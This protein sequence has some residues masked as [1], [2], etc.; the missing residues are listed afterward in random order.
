MQLEL[1]VPPC[2]LFGWWFI[3]RELW[4]IGLFD[5]LSMGLQTP[6][7][8]SVL[9]LTPPLGNPM[10]KPM[11]D[12]SIEAY[13]WERGYEYGSPSSKILVARVKQE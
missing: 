13:K 1:L 11:V 10:L 5:F 2:V 6:S 9:S 3:S 8:P 4:W 7:A 12:I